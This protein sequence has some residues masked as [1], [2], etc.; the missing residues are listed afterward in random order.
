MALQTPGST[1]ARRRVVFV[2]QRS[3]PAEQRDPLPHRYQQRFFNNGGTAVSE[4]PRFDEPA[5]QS[6]DK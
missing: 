5:L 4:F 2:S 6:P 3:V 1:W